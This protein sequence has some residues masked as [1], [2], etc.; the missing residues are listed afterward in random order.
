MKTVACVIVV[1]VLFAAAALAEEGNVAFRTISADQTGIQAI[2]KKWNVEELGRQ[3]GKWQSHGWWPWGLTAFDFDGDGDLD[4]LPTHHGLPHGI[5]LK[6]LLKES[7][8]L[9]FIHATKELGIDSRALPGADGKPWI[10]D[11]DGDGWLA[12]GQIFQMRS[13]PLENTD[14]TLARNMNL[15]RRSEVL[16]VVDA[17]A[18][19]RRL[20]SSTHTY[21]GM[22]QIMTDFRPLSQQLPENV[23]KD[24]I[25]GILVCCRT[26]FCGRQ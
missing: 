14:F 18:R 2:F 22:R 17:A 5:L 11:F 16:M 19:M 9:T 7:G 15:R 6:S 3:G 12:N 1:L 10:W 23:L 24:P 13:K 20:V 25:C 8:K 4:L 21:S 26:L